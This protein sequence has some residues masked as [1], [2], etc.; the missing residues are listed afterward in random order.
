MKILILDAD[1]I[2]LDF[3]I[4]AQNC[5]HKVK[6]YILDTPKSGCIG[7]GMV[8]VIRDWQPW[9][10]WADMVFLPDNTK[11]L[12]DAD[13]MRAEG[14]PVFGAT[15]LSAPWE[16]DRDVGMKVLNKAGVKTPD[17]KLFT[18]YDKAIAYVKKE[19][20]RFVSKPSGDGTA[21]KALSYCSK[22]AVDMI[23]MLQRWKKNGKIKGSF[24]LQEFI[25]GVEIAVGG[26]F[27]PHGFNS[28]VCENFEF[29]KLMNGDLGVAT[30]EMGTVLHYTRKSKLADKVLFPIT[31]AL[32]K[33]GHVGYVDVNCIVDDNGTPWPLEFTM[34]PGWPTFNIMQ[35]LHDGDPADWMAELCE[36]CDARNTVTNTVAV[37]VCVA[38]PD[39]PYSNITRKEVQGIPIYGITASMWEYIHPC[40]MMI[41][42]AP[43]QT[44][45]GILDL[46]T[47][48]TAGDYVM[49]V[50]AKGPTIVNAREKVYRRLDRIEIP[51]S[52]M[53]RTDIGMKLSTQLPK[54]QAKGIATGLMYS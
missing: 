38:I 42:T 20:R 28:T 8:D 9:R 5:G 4:R 48:S 1:G 22:S 16:I 33:T 40:E 39:F 12:R 15:Q 35:I 34:R 26:W 41:T 30:G 27:G 10:R 24:F 46:P 50:T 51:N 18:D 31:D 13:A 7:K 19:G 29:K 2:A 14:I 54:L 47:P 36:G 37:G 17:S 45:G 53:W 11:Y 43:N 23:Y 3:A 49:V 25:P 52:P 6:H 21:D 32:H 44:S